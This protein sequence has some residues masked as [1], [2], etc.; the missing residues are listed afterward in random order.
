MRLWDNKSGKTK[1]PKP[2]KGLLHIEELTEKSIF[3]I[4][5]QTSWTSRTLC[6]QRVTTSQGQPGT[7]RE[8][9]GKGEREAFAKHGGTRVLQTSRRP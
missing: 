1:Q 4:F 7:M 9:E 5:N 2:E 3:S 8:P 6:V